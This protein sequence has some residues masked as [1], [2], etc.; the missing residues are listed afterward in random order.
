MVEWFCDSRCRISKGGSGPWDYKIEEFSNIR[1][2]H[3]KCPG[4]QK[5]ERK[6]KG[7]ENWGN[8]EIE[9]QFTD[10]F[11]EHIDEWLHNLIASYKGPEKSCLIKDKWK[12]VSQT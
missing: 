6:L 10:Y 8:T 11:N 2:A 12:W 5:G 9:K 7:K 4:F 3:K 1:Q